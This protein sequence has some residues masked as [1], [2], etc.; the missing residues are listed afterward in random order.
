MDSDRKSREFVL[1]VR[2][3]DGDIFL[4]WKTFLRKLTSLLWQL[5]FIT[6][7]LP[8]FLAF[9]LWSSGILLDISFLESSFCF[10][11]KISYLRYLNLPYWGWRNL[12]MESLSGAW[13]GFYPLW[14]LFEDGR[15]F[16]RRW[17]FLGSRNQYGFHSSY[18]RCLSTK[19]LILL[20]SIISKIIEQED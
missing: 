15:Q 19:C 13:I 6:R 17:T 20:S 11:S 8:I 10:W 5:I 1:S 9:G 3:G 4:R 14:L 12:S 18:V 2:L 16:L 7:I